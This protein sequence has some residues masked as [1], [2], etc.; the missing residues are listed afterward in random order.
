MF[1]Q[2]SNSSRNI[3]ESGLSQLVMGVVNGV[4]RHAGM[5]GNA[6]LDRMTGFAGWTGRDFLDKIDKINEIGGER[7]AVTGGGLLVAGFC[8]GG[9]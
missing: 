4:V 5:S 7:K 8:S 9:L 6:L 3:G 2:K 1:L